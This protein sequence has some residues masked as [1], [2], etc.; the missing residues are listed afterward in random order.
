MIKK[1]TKIAEQIENIKK[2]IPDQIDHFSLLIAN[3]NKNSN[4]DSKRF[5][6][7]KVDF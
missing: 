1:D 5:E 7:F 3:I 6:Y 2:S 4:I